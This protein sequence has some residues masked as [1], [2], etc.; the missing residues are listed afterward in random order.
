M[1]V[2]VESNQKETGIPE[3]GET[4][5]EKALSARELRNLNFAWALK[6]LRGKS[7]INQSINEAITVSRDGLGE[8]KNATKSREQALSVK[9]LGTLL[10][11]AEYWKE[12]PHI[13]P[14]PNIEKVIYFKQHCKINGKNYIAVITVKVYKSQN[15]RKYYHH[16]LDDFVL[17]PEK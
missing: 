9:L 16:Y 10:E 14:D 17:E 11:V 1:L 15:Y 6:H 13:P 4:E 8:W 2:S 3:I 7:F 12:G 5:E